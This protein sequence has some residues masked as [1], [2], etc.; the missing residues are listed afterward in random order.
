MG[1]FGK[2][3][4]TVRQ[5][6]T[7]VVFSTPEGKSGVTKMKWSAEMDGQIRGEKSSKQ[8]DDRAAS[9]RMND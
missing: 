6:V 3:P 1:Y 2:R 8:W 4:A 7:R 9:G 5:M